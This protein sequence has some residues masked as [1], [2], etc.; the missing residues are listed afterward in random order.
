MWE[1]GITPPL[2]EAVFTYWENY[3]ATWKISI[4]ATHIDVRS[5]KDEH[6]DAQFK[7]LDL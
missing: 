3:A 7:T 4:L 1:L 2:S 5:E 6:A